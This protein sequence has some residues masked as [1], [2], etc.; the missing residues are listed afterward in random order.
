MGQGSASRSTS[1]EN[2]NESEV[3]ATTT[4]SNKLTN[5]ITSSSAHYLNIDESDQTSENS[6]LMSLNNDQRA[7]LSSG[8]T[9]DQI[10]NLSVQ[11]PKTFLFI[12]Q[13]L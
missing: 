7:L 6:S 12:K 1:Q 10:G 3:I 13:F 11:K 5:V 2:E 4:N 8:S 9:V